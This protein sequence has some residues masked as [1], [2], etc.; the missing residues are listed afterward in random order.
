M[1]AIIRISHI[2]YHEKT[3]DV[4]FEYYQ[5]HG[6]KPIYSKS[7]RFIKIHAKKILYGRPP[8]KTND[9]K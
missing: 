3:A 7:E 2:V 5:D 1:S 8:K 4:T 6:G 9:L